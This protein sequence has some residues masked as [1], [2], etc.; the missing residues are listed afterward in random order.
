MTAPAKTQPIFLLTAKTVF[1]LEDVLAAELAALGATGIEPGRRLVNFQ[2]DR[3][4]LYRANIWLRTAIRILRPIHAFAARDERSLYDGVREIDWSQHVAAEGS[5]AIDPVVHNSFCTHSLFAAQLAKDAIV[6]QFR[7]ACG[8]RPSVDL[9][10]PDLRINLHLNDNRAT[11][12]LDSSGDSL[13]KRGY[14]A[15]AGEA[16]LNEVL[17]AGILHLTGWDRRSAFVDFMCGSG[18]LPIEAA[19]WARNIAPGTIRQKFA[20]MRWPDFDRAAR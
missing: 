18:T 4:L 20:Y 17:A 7:D 5:L 16:P 11:V 8:T 9:K 13:H 10:N 19:L 1:G 12:Y 3:R 2:A 14:R 15:A 6:D